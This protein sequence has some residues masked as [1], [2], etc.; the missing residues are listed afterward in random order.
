LVGR[1][2][3]LDW[4]Y[5]ERID[6]RERHAEGGTGRA[7]KD[8]LNKNGEVDAL[9]ES[10]DARVGGRVTEAGERALEE[11]GEEASV[12]AGKLAVGPK[13]RA[14]VTKA[15]AE[16]VLCGKEITAMSS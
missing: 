7:G 1:L 13:G 4:T 16:P 14:C 6:W 5:L 15:A 2:C 3:G 11:G 8:R 10:D 9:K 12:E